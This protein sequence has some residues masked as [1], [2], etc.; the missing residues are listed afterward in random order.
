MADLNRPAE[1]GS[2]LEEP[3]KLPEMINVLTILTFVGC[4]LGFIGSFWTFASAK[5]NYEK[6]A[7]VNLDQM[8]DFVKKLT[9]GD[10]LEMARKAY[11]LRLPI[12]LM[13]L[14]GCGLCLYGAI[15]MRQLKK[16]GF[17]IYTIGE[18]LPIIISVVLMGSNATGAASIVGYCIYILFVVLY[19]TQLKYLK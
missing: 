7:S 16:S 13:G 9:G 17:T 8:P 14:I 3:K 6:L 19:A 12:L 4:G 11:E 5:G 15:Q 2:F 1:P 10:P 18:L